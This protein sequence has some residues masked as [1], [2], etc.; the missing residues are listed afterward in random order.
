MRKLIF[1]LLPLVLLVNCKAVAEP[2]QQETDVT[3]EQ[4]DLVNAPTNAQF[5]N[6]KPGDPLSP[7]EKDGTAKSSFPKGV[8]LRLNAIVTKS[9]I[10]ID[11]F[12]K[13]R[14]GIEA[15]VNAAKAAPSDAAAQKR[16]EA[17]LAKLE[18]LHKDAVAAKAEL[19][20]EGE[21]LLKTNA[22]YDNVIFSGMAIFVTKVASELADE[23]KDMKALLA[24]K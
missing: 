7:L 4:A 6:A 9:K 22:Y 8:V 20:A 18:T 15:A 17:A 3:T 13:E 11:Q 1:T 5:Q 24:N 10:A 23:Q 2:Q 16:A 19:S 12:D 14:P 21:M